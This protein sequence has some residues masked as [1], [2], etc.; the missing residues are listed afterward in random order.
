[1]GDGSGDWSEMSER[2]RGGRGWL[3]GGWVAKRGSEKVGKKAVRMGVGMCSGRRGEER[4]GFP[5]HVI[6]GAGGY[7]ET[8]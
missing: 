8:G 7:W 6:Y 4:Y 3:E 1:M 2:E 5:A